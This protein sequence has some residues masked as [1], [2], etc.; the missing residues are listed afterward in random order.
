[1]TVGGLIAQGVAVAQNAG[2][3]KYMRFSIRIYL[4]VVAVIQAVFIVMIIPIFR[5]Q[6]ASNAKVRAIVHPPMSLASSLALL[7]PHRC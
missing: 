4:V 7:L 1:M 5:A 3:E 2:E 6:G